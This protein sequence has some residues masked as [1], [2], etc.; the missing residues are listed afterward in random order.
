MGVSLFN[1]G[2][3]INCIFNGTIS[4]NNDWG[5]LEHLAFHEDKVGDWTT[6]RT[7]FNACM[8]LQCNQ[9]VKDAV[10]Q[11]EFKGVFFTA[12]IGNSYANQFDEGVI[13]KN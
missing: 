11:A 6:F 5:D 2:I 13:Q 12:D 9:S 8:T 10:E 3:R 4:R 7:M 1:V